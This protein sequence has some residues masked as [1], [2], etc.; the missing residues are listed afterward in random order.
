MA[1]EFP[2]SYDILPV[3]EDLDEATLEFVLSHLASIALDFE[4]PP[5]DH[6]IDPQDPRSI[7]E[8]VTSL[9]HRIQNSAREATEKVATL[10]ILSN[11]IDFYK[12]ALQQTRQA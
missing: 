3:P 11:L 7:D 10:K 1:G 5:T 2:P 8:F 4:L 12:K 6:Q 9:E